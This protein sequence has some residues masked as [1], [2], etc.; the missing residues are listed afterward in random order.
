[1]YKAI[2]RNYRVYSPLSVKKLDEEKAVREVSSQE[3]KNM[4]EMCNTCVVILHKK[5]RYHVNSGLI[6]WRAFDIIRLFV[7]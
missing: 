5:N 1:M 7:P 6:Y 3:K 4:E 2:R